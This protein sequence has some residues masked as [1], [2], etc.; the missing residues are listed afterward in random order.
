MRKITNTMEKLAAENVGLRHTVFT[1]KSKRKR[2]KPLFDT[3]RDKDS[4][5][6]F[7]SPAKITQA[8]EALTLREH[9]K[10]LQAAQRAE[11]KLQK[12]T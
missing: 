3:L 6:I 10:Q 2:G 8:R 7:F 9:K 1:E 12:R 11:D 4:K 5:A